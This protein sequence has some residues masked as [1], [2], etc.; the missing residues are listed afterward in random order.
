MLRERENRL[1]RDIDLGAMQ[2]TSKII[3]FP[4]SHITRTESEIQFEVDTNAAQWHEYRMFQHVARSIVSNK[5]KEKEDL[6][7]KAL[8]QKSPS[9]CCVSGIFAGVDVEE[10]AFDDNE[11]H[12]NTGSHF[13]SILPEDPCQD[14][15]QDEYGQFEDLHF[16]I[17]KKGD[18]A[19][20][21]RSDVTPEDI[22]R[23]YP[24]F[25]VD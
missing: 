16:G 4:E 18:L 25:S 7:T 19:P 15:G 10:E 20:D 17:D 11:K 12:N 6:L 2:R 23:F 5:S 8:C 24:S 1:F 9:P 21:A 3:P 13:I 14:A 22:A